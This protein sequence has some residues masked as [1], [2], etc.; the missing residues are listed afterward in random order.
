MVR[1][2]QQLLLISL[3]R[4]GLQKL[5]TSENKHNYETNYDYHDYRHQSYE[6]QRDED[7]Y[8]NE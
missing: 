4:V 2:L 5:L 7:D 8:E 6:L 1:H 3:S